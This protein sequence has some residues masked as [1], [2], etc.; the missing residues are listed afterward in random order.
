MR[1]SSFLGLDPAAPLLGRSPG[2]L[3]APAPPLLCIRAACSSAKPGPRPQSECE[4]GPPKHLL[5]SYC[6][7]MSLPDG[8]THL[9]PIFPDGTG[10]QPSLTER[11]LRLRGRFHRPGASWIQLVGK[12]RRLRKLECCVTA[13]GFLLHWARQ[14]AQSFSELNVNLRGDP[15]SVSNVYSLSLS[16]SGEWWEAPSYA[17]LPLLALPPPLG[18]HRGQ[19]LLS[20]PRV[21]GPLC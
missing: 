16:G 11:E 9:I 19:W 21:H 4:K 10:F 3:G 2:F 12:S 5:G 20:L 1:D 17:S 13:W 6:R 15:G 14:R 8:L 7:R 18:S